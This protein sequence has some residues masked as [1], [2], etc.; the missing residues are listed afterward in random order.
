MSEDYYADWYIDSLD[1]RGGFAFA[2]Y[3]A[4]ERLQERDDY[5]EPIS[6]V[7]ISP[8]NF[9][10]EPIFN[11]S[12][13]LAAGRGSFQ[14]GL[15]IDGEEVRFATLP[16]V[17]TF[18]ARLYGASGGGDAPGGGEGPPLRPEGGA[19]PPPPDAREVPEPE[20]SGEGKRIDATELIEN[21]IKEFVESRALN[22]GEAGK[23]FIWFKETVHRSDI[24]YQLFPLEA[25][26]VR[27][28]WEIWS[29]LPKARDHEGL[30]S[31]LEAVHNL[32]CLVA[33]LGLDPRR[34]RHA[35]TS[36]ANREW[37]SELFADG[38]SI[39]EFLHF[40][41]DPEEWSLFEW[42]GWEEYLF[43]RYLDPRMSCCNCDDV[44]E[45]LGKVPLTSA[46]RDTFGNTACPED[47]LSLFSLLM[48]GVAAPDRLVGNSA[49]ETL[50]EFLFAAC[51]VAASGDCSYKKPRFWLN[52][53][54]GVLDNL[55]LTSMSKLQLLS[56]HWLQ[57]TF[58]DR[59]LPMKL[60]QLI[61]D[62]PSLAYE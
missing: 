3:R 10:A 31:W 13:A 34:L 51:A 1:A 45:L 30:L 48:V 33:L 18:V 35:S 40:N 22:V 17:T 20:W 7:F 60:E 50:E 24:S 36:S 57:L 41:P 46:S 53:S 16:D 11:R 59:A 19:P 9:S 37:F 52:H 26:A 4:E 42:Y 56:L 54:A 12:T 14:E 43:G 61:A 47:R 55:W 15:Y 6:T 8:P 62:A 49:K 23:P 29:R 44:I 2:S 21:G 39:P 25:A 58:P 32:L 27:L 28:E 5:K 38:G